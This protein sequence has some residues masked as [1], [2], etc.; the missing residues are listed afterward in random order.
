MIKSLRLFNYNEQYY[1][2]NLQVKHRSLIR[3]GS[4]A[5][6]DIRYC[7]MKTKDHQR[8]ARRTL[9]RPNS[10]REVG[11]AS[12]SDPRGGPIEGLRLGQNT[13]LMIM[14]ARCNPGYNLRLNGYLTIH[15]ESW[16]SLLRRPCNLFTLGIDQELEIVHT[17]PIARPNPRRVAWAASRPSMLS[18][19]LHFIGFHQRHVNYLPDTVEKRYC[20]R[21]LIKVC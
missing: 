21:S 12:L 10:L 19:S 1:T 2:C 18:D 3:Y 11:Q 5:N 14:D 8:A 20:Y 17:L 4:C 6:L 7:R 13:G 9:T 16:K 15:G